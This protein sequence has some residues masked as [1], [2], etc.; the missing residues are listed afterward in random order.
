M[1][2][3]LSGLVACAGCGPGVGPSGAADASELHG[4]ANLPDARALLRIERPD[5]GALVLEARAEVALTEAERRRGLRG[6]M[7]L[8]PG[9]AL[10]I[11]L[12]L[13]LDG[14]CVVNDGVSFDIDAVFACADGTVVAV[15]HAIAAGDA[16]ARCHDQTRW[17]VETAAGQAHAVRPGDR[18]SVA[19]P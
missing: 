11:E 3:L 9:E 8:A 18:L 1:I 6:H 16:S 17:I 13:E 10:L 2:A 4:D 7:P 19:I 5:S 12:P 14:V 15:E